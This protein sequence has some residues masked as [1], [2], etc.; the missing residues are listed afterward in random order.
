MLVWIVVKVLKRFASPNDKTTLKTISFALTSLLI[1]RK[2]Q[3]QPSTLPLAKTKWRFEGTLFVNLRWKFPPYKIL[4]VYSV[5]NKCSI[6]LFVVTLARLKLNKRPKW[7]WEISNCFYFVSKLT[8]CI[9][10]LNVVWA[11]PFDV[12]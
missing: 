1:H 9:Y 8:A 2:L 6:N 10:L 4:A 5:F 11:I 7:N 12:C 3:K